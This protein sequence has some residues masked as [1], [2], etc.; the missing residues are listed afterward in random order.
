MQI[1]T[2]YDNAWKSH[3]AASGDLVALLCENDLVTGQTATA[4][5][6][7]KADVLTPANTLRKKINSRISAA[8]A[9]DGL[10]VVADFKKFET[11]NSITD[12]TS[13]IEKALF[14]GMNGDA[15][16]EI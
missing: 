13:I 16:E 2:S 4:K 11:T 5:G 9:G 10:S 12:G 7:F 14:D 1:D 6:Q 3:A 8:T 15:G